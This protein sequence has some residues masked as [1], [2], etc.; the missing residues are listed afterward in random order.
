MM[1]V[2]KFMK[3][4]RLWWALILLGTVYVS[5]RVVGLF[6]EPDLH[7]FRTYY[8]ATEVAATGASPYDLEAVSVASGGTVVFPFFYPPH[9]LFLFKPFTVFGPDL[10]ARIYLLLKVCALVGLMSIWTRFL[11]SERRLQG[12]AL[13]VLL[14]AGGFHEAAMIDLDTGNVSILE[15]LLLWAGFLWFIRGRYAAFAA[16]T[17]A[18]SLFK[19]F[20]IAF[21]GLLLF[22]PRRRGWPALAGGVVGFLAVHGLSFLTQRPLYEEFLGLTYAM[23]ERG[24]MNPC[25]LAA[26][27]DVFPGSQVVV[28]FG[29]TVLL[30]TGLFLERV[31]RNRAVFQP[32]TLIIG[33]VLLL[34]L[35]APRMK[36]YSYV[37]LFLPAVLA[38]LKYA[39]V[40]R[41]V[42]WGLGLLMFA[43]VLAYQSLL[44]ALLLFLLW[45]RETPSLVPG[46]DSEGKGLV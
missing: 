41:P 23:N 15:Q 40:R 32:Q 24:V 25:T 14:V 28:V 29:L 22:V 19:I 45:L 7:D 34:T 37:L 26:V 43:G 36:D 42:A 13:L 8:F 20:P 2:R 3:L 31:R 1:E 46:L 21:L 11:P 10:A 18:A 38:L 9:V 33:A 16:L 30:V 39:E 17:L 4:Q 6:L 5:V 27:R 44:V 12:T 35:A